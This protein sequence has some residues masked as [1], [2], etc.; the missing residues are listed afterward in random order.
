MEQAANSIK[1]VEHGAPRDWLKWANIL[2]ACIGLFIA[3][4]IMYTE[5]ANVDPVCP[6]NATF[7]CGVVQHSVYS[8]VGPIPVGYLG[9]AG[10]LAIF[11]AL[12]FETRVPFL[13]ER[14]RLVVF[15]LALFGVVFS[16]Y[17]TGVE[18]FILHKWCAWCLGS[19]ITMTVLFLTS[20]GRVWR[21]IN[22]IPEDDGDDA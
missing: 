1:V 4:Y 22:T 2:L 12:V 14:G 17:L 5:I 16:G 8:H 3:G 9:M 11:L 13:A 10:Y 19:A 15:G 7:D 21:D 20:F 18:A 6:V